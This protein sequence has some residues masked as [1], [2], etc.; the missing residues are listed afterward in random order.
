VKEKLQALRALASRNAARFGAVMFSA[1]P[2][3]SSFAQSTP[4]ADP[5]AAITL[6][7]TA[8]LAIV[9]AGGAAF[10]TIK[11]AL[12]GWTVGAKFIG[13]LGGKA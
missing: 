5:Q 4:P 1:G 12:V 8:I 6:A 9:A 11:L 7:V 2:A 10:V 13:R 3:L